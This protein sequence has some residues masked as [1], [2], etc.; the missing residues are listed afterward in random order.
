[1]SV[2]KSYSVN[3]SSWNGFFCVPQ[4]IADR[5]LKLA[6]PVSLKVILYILRQGKVDI[7]ASLIAEALGINKNDVD[8]ALIYWCGAGIIVSKD[9]KQT[10]IKK[11]V[12]EE[13]SEEIKTQK[14]PSKPSRTIRPNFSSEDV[15]KALSQR[16]DLKYLLAR[17]EEIFAHP[18]SN[19]VVMSLFTLCEWDGISVDIICMVMERCLNEDRLS[20]S[21]IVSEARRWHADGIK[22]VAQADSYIIELDEKRGMYGK[23]KSVFGINNRN[24]SKKEK[25]FIDVWRK[26]FGFDIDMITLAFE[27]CVNTK[28]VLSFAYINSVLNNWYNDG[29]STPEAV[30]QRE[31]KFKNNKTKKKSDNQNASYDLASEAKKALSRFE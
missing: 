27:A 23:V 24:L 25:N 17:S 2:S 6:S 13:P 8:D 7:D 20:M 19:S 12:K 15:A 31:E 22:T 14:Q 28:G 18:L 30:K 3:F 29:V 21:N 10:I 1:M 4:E 26:D 16:E 11:E 9:D 5:H